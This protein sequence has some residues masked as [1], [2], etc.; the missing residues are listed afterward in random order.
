MFLE[1]GVKIC[2]QTRKIKYLFYLMTFF[3]CHSTLLAQNKNIDS[4]LTLLKIYKV[5]TNRV[6]HLYQLAYEYQ[7]VG[8]NEK[9]LIYGDEALELARQLDFKK[10]IAQA[11]NNLGSIYL[12]Q[13]DYPHALDYF[14]KALKTDEVLKNKKGIATRLGNIGAVFMLQ[15]DLPKALDWYFKAL[16]M[17]EE[18]GDKSGITRYLINIGTI[19]KEQNDFAKSLVFSFKAL[20]MAE[21]LGDENYISSILNNIGIVY[22]LQGERSKALDFYSR[23]LHIAETLKNKRKISINLANMGAIYVEM[24]KFKE[25]EQYLKKAALLTDSIGS[26]YYLKQAEV[27]L[28]ELY[29]RMNRYKDAFIHYKKAVA[30]NDTI[31]SQENKKQIV[32]KEMQYD[33]DKKEIAAKALQDKRDAVTAQEKKRQKVII[34]SISSGL[35]LV[36]LLAFFI[37]RG[38]KLKQKA[39]IIITQQKAEVE[40]QKELVEL[41]N[42]EI[43]DSINYAKRIQQAKL[44][45]K[46]EIYSVLPQSFVLFKPKDIVSGDFYFFHKNEQF[47]FIASADCT[48]HGVPG[49]FMSMIGSEKLED[50]VLQT[51]DT[52]D[53]LSLLNKGIKVALKQ[54]DSDES[55]RDG[56]DIAFCSLNTKNRVVKYAGANRP[57]WIVRKGQTEIEETKATKKAIGGFTEDEQYFDT[58]ELQLHPGDTFYIFTDGYADQF[59]GED[60]KKLMTKK[61]KEILLDIQNKTM[62]EQEKHLDTFV[63]NWRGKREQIDDIL[64]IGVRL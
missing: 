18:L 36:L 8:E 58:H 33:F 29:Q 60:G 34:Y 62:K 44:P 7:S 28:T 27:N 14:L 23:A 31:F 43:T 13:S 63:E 35:F 49:A 38:Y 24:G 15:G 6:I 50:A 17:A 26:L 20:K 30:L 55:T 19:Y 2:M 10:G 9:G 40:K 37:F 48:G 21:E 1:L 53:I 5:D 25:A 12:E 47:I 3:F 16:K 32:R 46:E 39:N 42:K 11:N 41:K 57:I 51:N 64:V 45:K 54:S 59:G 4:L 22:S 56:M 61:F 52:S